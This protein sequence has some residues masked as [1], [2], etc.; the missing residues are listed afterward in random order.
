[1]V[2]KKYRIKTY[3]L[4]QSFGPFHYKPLQKMLIFPLFRR[5]LKYPERIFPRDDDS[6]RHI[7]RFSKENVVCTPDLVLQIPNHNIEQIFTEPDIAEKSGQCPI[8][9]PKN[10]VLVVPNIKV[11]ENGTNVL[12]AYQH[13]IEMLLY[14]GDAVFIF[15]HSIADRQAAEDIKSL[16]PEET[17]VQIINDDLNCIQVL[18]LLKQ[19]KFV[20]A[21]RFHAIV[22]SYKVGV[23]VLAFGWSAKYRELMGLFEQLDYLFDVRES[24]DFNRIYRALERLMMENLREAETIR[25]KMQS[26]QA[27]G[28]LIED[29]LES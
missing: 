5:Y 12:Q 20:L 24:K 14:E 7:L 25:D 10:S 22:H 21:A 27:G 2:F 11:M 9:I 13:L 8:V 23:P 28:N 26:F 16:F 6:L 1:M 4:P 3:L 17:G 19:F 18:E 29:I 15:A